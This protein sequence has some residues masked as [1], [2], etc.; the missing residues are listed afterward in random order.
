MDHLAWEAQRHGIDPQASSTFVNPVNGATKD[1]A[2][3]SGQRDWTS[4]PCPGRHLY[5]QLPTV[6]DTVAAALAADAADT[7]P[8]ATPTGLTATAGDGRVDLDWADSSETDL[9]GYLVERTTDGKAWETSVSA[10]PDTGLTNGTTYR[11]RVSA[12]DRSG[13][14]SAPT[15][16]VSATPTTPASTPTSTSEVETAVEVAVHKDTAW[17]R[18]AVDDGSTF[19]VDTVK[20]GRD[21]VTAWTARFDVGP[22]G[23]VTGLVVD[24]AG[25]SSAS[26]TRV[27]EAYDPTTRAWREVTSETVGAAEMRTTWTAGASWVDSSGQL[28]LRVSTTG[29]SSARTATDL[30]T[31]TV[32]GTHR[33]GHRKRLISRR[34]PPTPSTAPA[35][36]S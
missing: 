17:S 8:P 29:S 11:Y 12:R 16:E 18:L 9:A 22:A 1:S 35:A 23:V 5:A 15:A 6:R 26:A 2:D 14:T 10:H 31:A 34:R 28:R 7:T 4:T 36:R 30:L 32:T 20:Q 21:H 19:D 24:L 3:I 25:A 33:D 27:L 13:N